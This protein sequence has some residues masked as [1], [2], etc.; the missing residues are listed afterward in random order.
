MIAFLISIIFF[1][2]FLFL[3]QFSKKLEI[4]IGKKKGKLAQKA[5]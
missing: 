4:L 5:E 1:L 3:R 2:R